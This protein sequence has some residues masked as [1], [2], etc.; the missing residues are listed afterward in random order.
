[1]L[2]FFSQEAV[3]NALKEAA[4]VQPGLLREQVETVKHK[5]RVAR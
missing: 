4:H 1:M 3:L 5:H 2:A